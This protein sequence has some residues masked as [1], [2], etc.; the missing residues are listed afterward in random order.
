[1]IMNAKYAALV[2]AVFLGLATMVGADDCGEKEVGADLAKLEALG[3]KAPG[4]GF[5][6]LF[7][8][9]NLNGWTG[10]CKGYSVEEGVLICNP[11]GNLLTI[12]DYANFEAYFE[13][14][15]PPGGNNGFGVRVPENGHA[16]YDGYELQILDNTAKKYE[17]LHPWQY[18]GSVYGII[19]AKRGFLK[20]VG[21][22]NREH[23]TVSGD[24]FKVVLNGETIV[25][26]TVT[27]AREK[28]TMDQKPHPGLQRTTGRLG[29]LGH[30]DRIEFR[31]IWVKELPN[32]PKK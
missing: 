28:G 25:D 13:F 7:N 26:G 5:I 1:M 2:S 17:A 14:K 15:L 12:K 4:E 24:H 18:H 32:D 22:W 16:S 30:G 8:G 19:P 10:D 20:P 31:S 23:V 3:C 29:F 21:E 6:P 9:E 27:E 11:G